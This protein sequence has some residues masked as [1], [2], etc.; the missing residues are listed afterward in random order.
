MH[1][2]LE[3]QQQ[4]QILHNSITKT[5]CSNAMTSIQKPL[6]QLYKL[7]YLIYQKHVLVLHTE[8][9]MCGLVCFGMIHSMTLQ[10]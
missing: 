7:W 5:N 8:L 2:A 4:D 6:T 3:L 10:N 9:C 1:W